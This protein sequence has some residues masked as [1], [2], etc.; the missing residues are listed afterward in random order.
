MDYHCTKFYTICSLNINTTNVFQF[1]LIF[2]QNLAILPQKHD[3]PHFPEVY[4]ILS[5]FWNIIETNH[6][7][8]LL[9]SENPQTVHNQ[10]H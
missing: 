3:V 4:L 10:L 9:S 1:F 8:P 6:S 7:S 5:H 2:S